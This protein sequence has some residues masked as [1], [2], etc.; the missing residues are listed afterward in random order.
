M[1]SLLK[2]RKSCFNIIH[3]DC[4]EIQKKEMY[5]MGLLSCLATV[6]S[7]YKHHICIHATVLSIYKHHICIHSLMFHFKTGGSV[8]IPIFFILR[9]VV[10]FGT[11]V[12]FSNFQKGEI[13]HSGWLCQ[14]IR[15]VHTQDRSS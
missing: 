4:S 3:I 8:N 9:Q 14:E 15:L 2:R 6:L 1:D 13:L 11:K 7:V 5:V 12:K 10:I